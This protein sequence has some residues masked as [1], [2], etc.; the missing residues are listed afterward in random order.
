MWTKSIK[1]KRTI[2]YHAAWRETLIGSFEEHHFHAELTMGKLQVYFPSEQKWNKI[3]P[4]WAAGLWEYAVN[5]ARVWCE[6]EKIPF[7]IDDN[8]W[9]YFVD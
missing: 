1:K 8:G 5:G 3:S 6:K 9:F 2:Y 7:S 4:E